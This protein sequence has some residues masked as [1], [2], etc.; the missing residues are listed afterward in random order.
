MVLLICLFFANKIVVLLFCF[1]IMKCFGILSPHVSFLKVCSFLL[2]E[3]FLFV[4]LCCTLILNVLFFCVVWRVWNGCSF[5]FFFV[6]L[7]FSLW[8][9][10]ESVYFLFFFVALWFIFFYFSKP[11]LLISSTLKTHLTHLMI[12]WV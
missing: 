11:I 6:V 9:T 8:F 10:F 12:I 5:L 4:L 1:F 7:W 2:Y 3:E